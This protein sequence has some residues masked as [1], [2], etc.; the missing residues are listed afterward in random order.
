MEI[1]ADKIHKAYGTITILD[2]VSFSLEKGQKVGLV[3][4]NG[5]GKTT[6]LKII[7]GV[8][9]P[10][11]GK[12]SIRRGAK[13]GYMPQD[14]S[15][16]SDETVSDYL[17]CVSGMKELE[18]RIDESLEALTDYEN[19]NG[20]AFDYRMEMTLAGF[21]LQNI[22]NRNINSLSSGQKSKVF[23]AGVLLSDPDI[24]VLDEPT[25]NLDLPALIWLENFLMRCETTCLMVS[26]DRLFL[27]R[28]VRKIFEIDWNTRKL[29]ITN[30]RYSDYLERKE[31][32]TSR[33]LAE[34]KAQQEEIKRLTDQAR[35][36][37]AEAVQGSRYVGTDND[38][39][40]RGFKR[41]RAAKSGKTAKAIEKRIEQMDVLEKPVERDA[42]RIHLQP[43]KPEGS[44]DINLKDVVAGYSADGFRV[45]PI[46]AHMSYGSR[47]LILGLNGSGK[48]T[49]LKTL[50]GELDLISGEVTVGN[51]LVVGNL[52][53]EH[54]NLPREE[55]IKNFL[56][57]RAGVEVQIAYALA[58]KFGFKAEE[59]DKEI[60]SLSPGGRAR[61]LFALFSAL[62]VNVLL[63]DEPTNHLDL[64]ALQALEEAVSQYEGTII[65]VSHD[66]HFLEKFKATDTY[67][68]L[69]GKLE[70]QQSFSLYMKNAEHEAKR[71]I[72]ML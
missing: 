13:L 32:E 46:S 41:D 29:I 71:L 68:L 19:R 21:G 12:I 58:V 51:A 45:G 22:S 1:K 39:F 20:Y 67:V 36:K 6:L 10:D 28:I 35:K 55:S 9:E 54:N 14:T 49:L 2:D 62:S 66:R 26:H 33:Q 23:M 52:T 25:N 59:I 57:R 72:S 31:K 43:T 65:L 47:T 11:G 34:H 61:L 7:A 16:V 53:Q 63:L 8:I 17:W 4:Y 70:R 27:D 3:G 69:D 64:E 56:I 50:S 42:F 15:L 5:T 18:Q 44:R 24:L 48:S 40:L 30:G 37:K 38:K 60:S